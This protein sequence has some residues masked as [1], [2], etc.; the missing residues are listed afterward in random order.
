MNYIF[1]FKI[2]KMDHYI[3][4]N[5]FRKVILNYYSYLHSQRKERAEVK[6]KELLSSF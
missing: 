6:V 3:D 2:K 1:Y 4:R 5:N